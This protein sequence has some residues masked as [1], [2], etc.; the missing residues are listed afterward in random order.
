M[1]VFDYST[2]DLFHERLC[3]DFTNTAGRHG[4][5]ADNH[6]N[7]Y[8]DLVSWSRY[9]NVFTEDEA[10]KLLIEAAHQPAEAEATFQKAFALREALYRIFSAV[11]AG[12][13]V[14]TADLN[15]FNQELSQ[16]LVHLRV[17]AQANEFAW[18]WADA[19]SNLGQMLWPVVWSA[20]ELMMSDD[21]KY[22]R[23]CGGSDC[24]WLFLDTSRNHSRRW[25]SM[26][27]CGNRAKARRH[28]QRAKQ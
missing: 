24:D 3:L 13:E 1:N 19:D 27:T 6:L 9:E 7:S 2:L 20:S 18:E 14:D 21:L 23:E 16:A 10:R 15:I 8:A 25:C 26:E 12:N 22:V 11:G 17:A 28:Y 5:P 4:S